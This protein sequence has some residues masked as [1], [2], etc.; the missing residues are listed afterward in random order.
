MNARQKARV[1]LLAAE[2]GVV[3]ARETLIDEEETH[4]PESPE[5]LAASAAYEEAINKRDR[6]R[7]GEE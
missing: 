2:R 5:A 3:Y 7:E 4:G 6:L 1:A